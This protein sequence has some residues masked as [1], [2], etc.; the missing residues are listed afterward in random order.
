[1]IRLLINLILSMKLDIHQIS[2]SIE[3]QYLKNLS[4]LDPVLQRHFLYRLYLSNKNKKNKQLLLTIAKKNTLLSN[5]LF[6]TFNNDF[7][8]AVENQKQKIH[9]LIPRYPHEKERFRAWLKVPELV[10]FYG[11]LRECFYIKYFSETVYL[12]RQMIASLFEKMI[13]NQE[14]ITKSSTH[15]ICI[16]FYLEY[17]GL[18]HDVGI[19]DKWSELQKIISMFSIDERS[20]QVQIFNY[21]YA[22]NHF[23]IC[24]S[25][26]YL[27]PPNVPQNYLD[28]IQK[29]VLIYKDKISLDLLM[30]CCLCC[31]LSNCHSE[32]LN[33]VVENAII[34]QFDKSCGIIDNK[35]E[36]HLSFSSAEHTNALCLLILRIQSLKGGMGELR[37]V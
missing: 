36:K 6:D 11:I 9:L 27:R 14:F 24:D 20:N 34:N 31:G 1:M 26:F 23:V 32:K 25:F 33:Y 4:L 30:E 7:D 29:N 8:R 19:T 17:L 12:N 16:I 5:S 2:N 13:L 15:A 37:L 28:D 18:L 3:H 10:L 22:L 35:K 21:L